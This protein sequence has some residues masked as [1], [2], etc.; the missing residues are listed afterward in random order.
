MPVVSP[1]FVDP[2]IVNLRDYIN[3]ILVIENPPALG[4]NI[5]L[6]HAPYLEWE[7]YDWDNETFKEDYLPVKFVFKGRVATDTTEW[8]RDAQPKLSIYEVDGTPEFYISD[9]VIYT[10]IPEALLVTT[11]YSLTYKYLTAGVKVRISMH[12]NTN[13]PSEITPTVHNYVVTMTGNRISRPT[14]PVTPENQG[15]RQAT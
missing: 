1:T 5:T 10:N 9:R 11:D 13:D 6:T 14:L 15:D 3:P 8:F 12:S 7:K 2:S 4:S